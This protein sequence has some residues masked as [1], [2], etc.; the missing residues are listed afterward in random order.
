METL[1]GVRPLPCRMR[2]SA[3]GVGRI[4]LSLAMFGIYVAGVCTAKRRL[5]LF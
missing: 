3:C 2:L 4:G 1:P 5:A